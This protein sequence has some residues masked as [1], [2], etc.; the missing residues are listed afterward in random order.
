MLFATGLGHQ[1]IVNFNNKS[2]KGYSTDYCIIGLVG[3][4][5]LIMN[6]TV[7]FFDPISDAGRVGFWDMVF[8]GTAFGFGLT[9]YCQTFI[10]PSD[11]SMATTRYVAMTVIGIFL[12]AASLEYVLNCP[13]ES[14]AFG[15]SLVRFAGL[16]PATS[17]LIKYF[18]QIRANIVK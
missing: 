8:A 5:F 15:L 9:C 11:P 16:V 18:F 3:F 7:G 6:Q 17:S 10:Y 14:Y 12:F 1:C 2:T 4:S 13:L